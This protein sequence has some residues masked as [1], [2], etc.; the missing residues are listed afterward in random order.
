[1]ICSPVG[2]HTFEVS[3]CP[4]VYY[5]TMAGT[6]ESVITEQCDQYLATCAEK[7]ITI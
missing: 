4:T 1:V 5:D 2:L 3:V 6:S 7:V